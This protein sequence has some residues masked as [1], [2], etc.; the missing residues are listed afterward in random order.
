MRIALIGFHFAEIVARLALALSKR[1]EVEVHFSIFA[2]NN[3]LTTSLRQE[4]EAAARVHYHPRPHRK[5]ML[6]DGFRLSRQIARFRPDVVHMQEAG[7]WTLWT[8]KMLSLSFPALVLT[9]H[10]PLPHS[11][12]LAARARTRWANVRLR[13]AADAIIVHGDRLIAEMTAVEPAAA[14]RVYSVPHGALGEAAAPSPPPGRGRFLFFGR[15]QAYK[16]LGILLDAVENLARRGLA[17]SVLVAGKGDD[18]DSHRDR[19]ARLPCVTLDDRF[20]PAEDVARL[21][22]ESDAIVM[23]YLEATQSGVGALALN[24]GRAAIV[25]DV[26]SIGEVIRDNENGL[27][28]PPGDA[29]ALADA[30]ARVLTEPGLNERLA[31][32]A[33]R[34]AEGELSWDQVARATERVYAEAIRHS[35]AKTR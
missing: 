33:A 7:G 16:G 22:A 14:G 26:G 31:R 19:I 15:I 30:M 8:A 1:H 10:D 13:R 21:F 24:A 23:P 6:R 12:D 4:L 2:A 5:F 27:V 28:V 32:G 29:A 20:I 35:G 11:G 3:E 34:T 9:V 18:L 25:S 17:F